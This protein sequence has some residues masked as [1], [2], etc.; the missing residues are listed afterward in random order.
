M[1]NALKTKDETAIAEVV[2]PKSVEEAVG[3][4]EEDLLALDYTALPTIVNTGEM[5][6]VKNGSFRLDDS[7]DAVILAASEYWY[8]KCSNPEHVIPGFYTYDKTTT[9][10][11]DQVEDIHKMWKEDGCTWV[12]QP[13]VGLRILMLAPEEAFNSLCLAN[14]S[15]TSVKRIKAYLTLTVAR[16][17]RLKPFQAV[18]R[19]SLAKNAVRGKGGKM[20]RPWEFSY[21]KE[22]DPR[23]IQQQS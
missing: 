15:P 12:E 9:S 3:L 20:F 23:I 14:I 10:S 7:F 4:P 5:F 8:H 6:Q 13:Y 19:F 2:V 1:A 17:H 16:Q 18:T 22:F 11:G 21:V